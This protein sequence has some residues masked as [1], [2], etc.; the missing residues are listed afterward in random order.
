MG[1][2]R[3]RTVYGKVEAG[4]TTLSDSGL[5]SLDG[6]LVKITYDGTGEFSAAQRTAVGWTAGFGVERPITNKLSWKLEYL[7]LALKAPLNFTTGISQVGGTTEPVT[8]GIQNIDNN[9]IRVGLNYR[10]N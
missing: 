6:G 10:L 1:V 8:G 9:V 3:N 5:F 7:Y 4:P 2:M